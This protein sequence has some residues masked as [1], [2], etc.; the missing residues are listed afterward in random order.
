V[1][2]PTGW[3]IAY[4][5]GRWFLE[6]GPYTP[7]PP[8][9]GKQSRPLV[10]A[11]TVAPTTA[12]PGEPSAFAVY[13]TEPGSAQSPTSFYLQDPEGRKAGFIDGSTVN[14][15]PGS[16]VGQD[17]AGSTTPAKGDPEVDPEPESA[18]PVDPRTIVVS[19]PEAG[20]VLHVS[21][22]AGSPYALTAQAWVEGS[23]ADS[24]QLTGTGS[25]V[26]ALVSSPAL[27][28]L[29]PPTGGGSGGPQ[30]GG[31]GGGIPDGASTAGG[32]SL[33]SGAAY[34]TLSAHAARVV[35]GR[36]LLSVSCRGSGACAGTVSVSVRRGHKTKVLERAKI[37][38]GPG[39]H[40]TVKLKPTAIGAQLLRTHRQT[41]ATLL[42]TQSVTAG[43]P[44]VV[45]RRAL[46]I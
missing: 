16:D 39:A 2:Y 9:V 20:T 43:K 32:S 33:R 5:T 23:V 38:L 8:K 13:D 22:G 28:T 25:G 10:T 24:D 37:D 14:E 26:D 42:V 3:L 40:A 11:L 31:S 27:E 7:P 6:L 34:G 4:T 41:H 36:V 15:I 44:R 45:L 35:G 29:A 46:S 30:S 1:L 21:A 12:T 17:P 18:P 19:S